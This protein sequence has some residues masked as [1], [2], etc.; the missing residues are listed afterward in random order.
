[1]HRQDHR[2]SSTHAHGDPVAVVVG[3]PLVKGR[4]QRAQCG[5]VGANVNA[6]SR[7]PP[8]L[9]ST[10]EVNYVQ[11]RIMQIWTHL[12]PEWHHNVLKWIVT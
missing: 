8:R 7:T 2:D 10:L 6:S 3:V 1:M 5:L 11:S 4:D 12:K 9:F